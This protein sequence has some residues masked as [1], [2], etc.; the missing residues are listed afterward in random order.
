MS[1]SPTEAMFLS[2]RDLSTESCAFD[3]KRFMGPNTVRLIPQFAEA[4]DLSWMDSNEWRFCPNVENNNKN[5]L[6]QAG[7]ASNL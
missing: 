3:G 1:I 5:H 7:L 4:Q 6:A 2:L